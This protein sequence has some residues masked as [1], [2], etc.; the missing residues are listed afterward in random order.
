MQKGFTYL[1]AALILLPF[2]LLLLLSLAAAWSFPSILP[3][4]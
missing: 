1:L 2:S 4:A 3:D